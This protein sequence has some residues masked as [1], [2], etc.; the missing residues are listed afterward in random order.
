MDMD[1]T[2][3]RLLND[4]EGVISQINDIVARKD[5]QAARRAMEQI[6]EIV[7]ADNPD[8]ELDT[9]ADPNMDHVL[10]ELLSRINGVI[11]TKGQRTYVIDET[12]E[13]RQVEEELR[14]IDTEIDQIDIEINNIR[15]SGKSTRTIVIGDDDDSETI[16]DQT[17]TE[18]NR[19]IEELTRRR[20]QLAQ[21][22]RSMRD[23]DDVGTPQNDAAWVNL[24]MQIDDINRQIAALEAQRETLKARATIDPNVDV[25]DL[26]RQIKELR[27]QAIS[28]SRDIKEINKEDSPAS[29]QVVANLRAQRQEIYNKI[30]E[31]ERQIEAARATR[32]VSSHDRIIALEQEIA[33]LE[34]R[35]FKEVERIPGDQFAIL[36][37]NLSPEN[38]KKG[39]IL[40]IGNRQIE[41]D[42]SVHKIESVFAQDVYGGEE[43]DLGPT[44]EFVLKEVDQEVDQQIAA[45][46][47]E[48]NDLLNYYR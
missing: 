41:L 18:I 42:P 2:M 35:R 29:A 10:H 27:E 22:L 28:I 32:T 45:K 16:E 36:N 1:I 15:R 19:R 24:K 43:A 47:K 23:A 21:E 17:V 13:G 26:E 11:E 38:F 6:A 44:G 3:E 30:T 34:Q 37:R 33:D 7:A 8:V 5:I 40:R 48:L 14:I 31:L 12:E 20:I 39:D 25:A 46:R 4:F 9:R